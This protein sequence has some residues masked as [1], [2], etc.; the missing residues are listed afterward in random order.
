MSFLLYLALFA[1]ISV[2]LII[3]PAGTSI[4]YVDSADINGSTGKIESM[5]MPGG[6][7]TFGS[8]LENA[9][10]HLDQAIMNLNEGNIKGAII[11]LNMSAESLSMHENEMMEMMKSMQQNTSDVE[12][13]SNR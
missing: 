7:M 5:M 3:L 11:Q 1:E 8:S 13:D 9:R 6:N 4:M 10:M 12:T 2:M